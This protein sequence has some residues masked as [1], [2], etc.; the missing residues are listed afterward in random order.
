MSEKFQQPDGEGCARAF[1]LLLLVVVGTGFA[2][3][4][5]FTVLLNVVLD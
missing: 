4:I 3:G 1:G 5:L 2:A